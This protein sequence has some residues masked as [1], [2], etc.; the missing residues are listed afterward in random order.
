MTPKEKKT[1]LVL[2]K[3]SPVTKAAVLCAIVLSVVALL[4]LYGT[5]AQIRHQQEQ[6]RQEAMELESG[7]EQLEENIENLGTWESALRIAL[8][9]LGFEFPDSVIFVPKD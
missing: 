6:M 4:A 9:E 8:E 7:N 1:K 3:S 2:R 5:I